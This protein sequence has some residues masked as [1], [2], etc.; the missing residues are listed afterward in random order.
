MK[1]IVLSAA[2]IAIAGIGLSSC[3]SLSQEDKAMLVEAEKSAEMAE[4][5]AQKAAEEAERAAEAAMQAAE[6][7]ERIH[8]K[9]LR[10]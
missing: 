5:S 9:T 7:A 1:K 8:S 6:R 2:F 3:A 4:A 10:K